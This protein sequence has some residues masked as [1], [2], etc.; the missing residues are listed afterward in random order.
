MYHWVAEITGDW[1]YGCVLDSVEPIRTPPL[2]PPKLYNNRRLNSYITM[3][4]FMNGETEVIG[5]SGFIRF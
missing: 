4:Y 2:Y 5:T 3:R 1:L